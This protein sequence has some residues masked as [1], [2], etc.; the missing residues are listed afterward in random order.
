MAGLNNV[1][2]DNDSKNCEKPIETKNDKKSILSKTINWVCALAMAVTLNVAN[3][4]EAQAQTNNI[5]QNAIP[6]ELVENWK[7]TD[8]PFWARKINYRNG[9]FFVWKKSDGTFSMQ[10]TKMD[11]TSWTDDIHFEANVWWENYV[12]SIVWEDTLDQVMIAEKSPE[13]QSAFGIDYD[14]M[15]RGNYILKNIML[16]AEQKLAEYMKNVEGYDENEIITT[17][18]WMARWFARDWITNPTLERLRWAYPEILTS[19]SFLDK[20]KYPNLYTIWLTESNLQEAN[21]I[22]RRTEESARR[23]EEWREIN[24]K[25]TWNN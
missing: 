5:P 19:F 7:L 16:S 8:I 17:L 2:I 13:R 6:V 10:I 9:E 1:N 11:E 25:L 15:T 20:N 21:I 4:K 23:T 3:P 22:T 14:R 12:F 24:R 18:N